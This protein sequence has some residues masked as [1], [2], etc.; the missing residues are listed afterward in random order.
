MSGIRIVWVGKTDKGFVAEG[1]AHYAK[2]I[3]PFQSLETVEIRPA[4]HSGRDPRQALE[5]EADAVLKRL[6]G[7]DPVVL[8][9]EGGNQPTTRAFADQLSGWLERP[10]GS[11][12]FVIGGAF[13]VDDRLKSRADFNL[14]LSRLTFPHQLVRVIL[15]EQLYRALSLLSG[16]GYHHE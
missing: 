13:G 10:G 8:L 4:V 2:R 5:L 9:D 12:T 14:S 3:K 7:A 16:H 15:L 11:P 1:V 6:V